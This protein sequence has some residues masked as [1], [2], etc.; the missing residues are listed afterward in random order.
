[1]GRED[2]EFVTVLC[3]VLWTRSL[4]R[5]KP[6]VDEEWQQACHSVDLIVVRCTGLFVRGS[7]T[8][9]ERYPKRKQSVDGRGE[10]AGT[11]AALSKT[12]ANHGER[13]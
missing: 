13:H 3:L 6:V 7:T 9:D 5:V 11:K 2:K 8:R 12:L 1:M 10:V 4:V